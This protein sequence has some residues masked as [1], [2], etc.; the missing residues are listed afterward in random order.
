[1][2]QGQFINQ[3]AGLQQMIQRLPSI[4]NGRGRPIDKSKTTCYGCQGIGH[5]AGDKE[6]PMNN[7]LVATTNP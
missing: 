7:T 1:M 2:N 4:G 6:C 5:W 3:P